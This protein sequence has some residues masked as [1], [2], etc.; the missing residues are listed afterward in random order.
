[1]GRD[2]R[3]EARE[4]QFTKWVRAHSALPAWKALTFSAREAYHHFKV[5]CFAETAQKN[6]RI[7][8]NNGSVFCSSRQLA[9]E[10]GC[11]PKTARAAVA[12][13]QAKGWLVCTKPS[14]LGA[15]GRGT[16]A[17]FRLTMMSMGAGK[18]FIPAT[19]EPEC[20]VEGEDYPVLEFLTSKPKPKKGRVKNIIP[21]PNRTQACVQI[22]RSNPS[23]TTS[24]ASK[25]GAVADQNDPFPASNSVPYLITIPMQ[26]TATITKALASGI[27]FCGRANPS[28]DRAVLLVKPSA[29]TVAA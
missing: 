17:H 22:G 28:I 11:T 24:P 3:N 2:K 6:G 4:E 1:M 16:S 18:T 15:E 23:K 19:K 21:G 5:R 7:E 25:L 14:Q 20:W 10:M 29:N 13:L 27:G 8:N 9:D 12:D 26:D